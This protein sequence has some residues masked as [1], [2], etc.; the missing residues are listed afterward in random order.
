[1]SSLEEQIQF[2][3][4]QLIAHSDVTRQLLRHQLLQR[5]HNEFG[6][7]VSV[8]ERVTHFVTSLRNYLLQLKLDA[9][10]SIITLA[11]LIVVQKMIDQETFVQK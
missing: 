1:M 7:D 4:N 5:C 2:T 10:V 8:D 6:H 11:T 3:A 9:Q